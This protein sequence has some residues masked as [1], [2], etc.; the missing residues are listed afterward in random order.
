MKGSLFTLVITAIHAAAI[1]SSTTHMEALQGRQSA[2]L[3]PSQDPFY[4]TPPEGY[5]NARPGDILRMRNTTLSST[6][7]AS[8]A[9][10][11]FVFRTTNSL[12]QP[13]WALNTLFVPKTPNTTHPGL[14]SYQVPYNTAD[15]DASISVLLYAEASDLGI[16]FTDI[17]RALDNGF[18]VTVPDHEGPHAAFSAGILYGHV[19][20]DNVR[21]SLGYIN[22]SAARYV[23]WGYSGGSLASMFTAELQNTYAPE[24]QFAGIAIGGFGRNVTYILE[25][26]DG[27]PG[28]GVVPGSIIGTLQQ[29]PDGYS[30]LLSGLK[31]SGPSNS[32]GFLAAR[33]LSA[34]SALLGYA[35]QT[36]LEDYFVTGR[37]FLL[38]PVVKKIFAKE[39]VL[40][41]RG[42]WN[43]P[44]YGYKT[45]NDE[46][47]PI[48]GA[49][50]LVDEFCASGA[51]VL[52]EVN[53]VG[54]HQD[55]EVNGDASAWRFLE[56]ALAGEKVFSSR[57]ATHGCTYRNVTIGI[58]V[59]PPFTPLVV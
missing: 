22:N 5:E 38:D 26:L 55:E 49:E 32:T 16:I 50:E 2:P 47:V 25:Y 43:M 48:A 40:E 39:W 14:L 8:S 24:L 6:F 31:T 19:T 15:V 17:Q 18:Y 30:Y 21:A 23:L 59:H 33:N 46:F 34:V 42:A 10:Y 13:L 57:Y 12:G 56:S 35:G 45:I 7:N 4:S 54:N 9:A 11:Q 58:E 3:V 29:Y 1:A 52:Y 44:I 53:T 37:Q 36:V 41:T 20:L 28:V 27:T 51:N